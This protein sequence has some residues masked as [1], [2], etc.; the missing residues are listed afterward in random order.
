MEQLELQQQKGTNS[1]AK[2]SMIIGIISVAV[3]LVSFFVFPL[4]VGS[5][6]FS[7]GVAALI[8]SL[9]TK[10]QIQEQGGVLSHNKMAAAGL[11]LGIIGTVL[12][13]IGL[14]VAVLATILLVKQAYG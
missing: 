7:L 6:G 5:L 2:A 11:I 9:I 3:I 8:L 1:L 13:L 10:K 12:G 14:F 4:A